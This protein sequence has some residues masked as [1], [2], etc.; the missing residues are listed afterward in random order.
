MAV[1]LPERVEAAR[2]GTNQSVICRMPSGWVA[3]CDQ[4]FLRGYCI[5]LADPVV[6][7][8]NDLDRLQRVEF[9]SDMATIGDALIEVT[10]SFRINYAILANTDPYLHAHIVPRYLSE[11]D[12]LRRDLPW[13]HPR[14]EIDAELFNLNRDL[15]LMAELRQ[16]IEKRL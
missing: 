9:L 4:Q 6:A 7:S 3:L 2:A 15:P 16:A 1:S 10:G 13:S 12:E 8:L 14:S 11:P 5:L